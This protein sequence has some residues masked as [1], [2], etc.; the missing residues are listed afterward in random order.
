MREAGRI[1][2]A[3]LA[4]LRGWRKPGVT[5]IELDRRAE[6]IIRRAW[7]QAFVQRLSAGWRAVSVPGLDLR[8]S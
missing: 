6:E 7:R 2:A 3:V 8:L 5:L 4:E 1:V